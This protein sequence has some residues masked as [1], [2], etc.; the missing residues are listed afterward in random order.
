MET[1]INGSSYKRWSFFR[2]RS[3]I[4]SASSQWRNRSASRGAQSVPIGMPTVCWKTRSPHWT[5]TLSIKKIP[6]FWKH[7][8]F[9][10]LTQQFVNRLII[11]S[12]NFEWVQNGTNSSEAMC[13]KIGWF[14][15]RDDLDVSQSIQLTTSESETRSFS[16]IHK[17]QC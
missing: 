7:L 13:S 5:N 15:Y 17:V 1:D 8:L 9:L 2:I 12:A 6:A 16:A 3:A 14:R 10:W 4:K 11:R